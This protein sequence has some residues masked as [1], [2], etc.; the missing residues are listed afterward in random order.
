MRGFAGLGAEQPLP[1]YSRDG[2]AAREWLLEHRAR[3]E[4]PLDL[5]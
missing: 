4:R 1:T 2:R 3:G 5:I